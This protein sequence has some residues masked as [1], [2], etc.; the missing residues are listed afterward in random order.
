MLRKPGVWPDGSSLL[1][2]FR[3]LFS[4]WSRGNQASRPSTR[5]F[6]Y[7]HY[8]RKPWLVF[9]QLRFWQTG[10]LGKAM[11]F[12]D[13]GA[14]RTTKQFSHFAKFLDEGGKKKIYHRHLKAF[15]NYEQLCQDREWNRMHLTNLS[16][17]KLILKVWKCINDEWTF[18]NAIRV[19]IPTHLS[20]SSQTLWISWWGRLFSC[21]FIMI[22]ILIFSMK[23]TKRLLSPLIFHYLF[24]KWL[25]WDI[26]SVLYNSPIWS[27]QWGFLW[28]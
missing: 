24:L 4:L 15:W 21:H 12:A 10:N 26:T 2:F 27:V 8:T 11:Q 1:D 25:Y 16:S 22:I 13:S 19:L 7:F 28:Y 3:D 18:Q 23:D 17:R 6:L 5:P 9:W 14:L 20:E